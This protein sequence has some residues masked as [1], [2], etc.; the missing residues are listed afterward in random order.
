MDETEGGV[1]AEKRKRTRENEKKEQEKRSKC[2][3]VAQRDL[4]GTP[5]EIA[6]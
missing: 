1:S 4:T 5:W 3:E 2:D 6:I